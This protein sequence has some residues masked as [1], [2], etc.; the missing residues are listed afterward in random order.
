MTEGK[1]SKRAEVPLS[2]LSM[3]DLSNF[4]MPPEFPVLV[5][6]D[7][8]NPLLGESGASAVFGPQKGATPE[9]VELLDRALSNYAE[10]LAQATGKDVR[11]FPGSGAAGGL[12]GG[13]MAL[14]HAELKSGIEM[15]MEAVG[16]EDEL[17]NCDLVVT[18]EGRL[19]EQTVHGKAIS[20]V[21]SR[22]KRMG[23]PVV[24]LAGSIAVE[25]EPLLKAAGLLCSLGIVPE[26][27]PVENAMVRGAE[28]LERA[29]Y[30]LAAMLRIGTELDSN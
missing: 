22:A 6:C 25:A 19:D 27:M 9:M 3:I 24:A 4:K 16:F 5:A 17:S 15:V 1:R 13:L 21:I 11:S 14:C 26:Q 12:G 28:L 29:A 7:V 10:L 8:D 18:G 2:A 20:G 30:G 23:K